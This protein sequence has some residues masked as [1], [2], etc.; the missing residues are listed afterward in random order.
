MKQINL[1]K[2]VIAGHSMGGVIVQQLAVK[3]PELFEKLI[4]VDSAAFLPDPTKNP[5]LFGSQS[6]SN[7]IISE[8]PEAI[9]RAIMSRLFSKKTLEKVHM[10]SLLKYLLPESVFDPNIIINDFKVG[11]GADLRDKIKHIRIPTLIIAA[12]DSLIPIAAAQFLHENIKGSVLEIIQDSGHMIMIEKPE[13]FNEV[14]LRFIG[15]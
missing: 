8:S 5:N 6:L 13:E 1:N 9:G 3:H 4:I 2:A 10:G 12:T 14:V 11:K 15:A 7:L